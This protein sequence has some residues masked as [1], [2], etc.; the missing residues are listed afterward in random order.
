MPFSRPKVN[1]GWIPTWTEVKIDPA[2]KTPMNRCRE[3][4]ATMTKTE[5]TCI[6][7][8]SAL[9]VT[10]NTDQVGKGF[11]VVIKILFF[12]SA[13]MSVVSLLV[14]SD[15]LPGMPAFS[16]CM[17]STLV[18]LIVKSSADQMMERKKG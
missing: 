3:C 15:L 6:S 4:H 5:T 8:G 7:C 16:K 9:E 12:I 18:L 2:D 13:G 1:C 10:T 17:V 14:P 11:R